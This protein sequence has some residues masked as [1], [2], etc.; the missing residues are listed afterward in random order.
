MFLNREKMGKKIKVT[1]PYC[2]C[3][4]IYLIFIFELNICS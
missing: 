4:V 2:N 1:V 3:K